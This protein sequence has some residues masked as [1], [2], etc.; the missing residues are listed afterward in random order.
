MFKQ[1]ISLYRKPSA[2]ELAQRELEESRRSLLEAQRNHAYY[3]KIAS[4]YE[5]R[6]SKLRK[7][8]QSEEVTA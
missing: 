1:F 2:N 4:F 8:L 5:T 7:Q 3:E 6:I